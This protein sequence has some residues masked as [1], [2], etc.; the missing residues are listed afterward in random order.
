MA[1]HHHVAVRVTD[2]ARATKFY[3][4]AFGAKVTVPPFTIEGEFA[5]MIADEPG[6]KWD[7]SILDWG[8]GSVELFAFDT[9]NH[10]IEQVPMARGNVIH[11]GLEVDDVPETLARVEAAGGRRLW[12]EVVD[13]EPGAQVIYVL[14]P[15]ENIIELL[16]VS[17]AELVEVIGRA[18]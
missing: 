7:T 11:F 8:G 16:N 14:D 13:L 15:D 3:E 1:S 12:P 4:E 10:P 5:E 2:M 18:F 17:P 9:P 6:A